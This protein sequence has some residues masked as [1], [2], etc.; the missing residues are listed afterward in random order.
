MRKDDAIRLRHMLDAAHE[1]MGFVQ[2]RTR[3]D[4]NDDR[5]LVL[6][7]VKDI[8]I[9]GEAAH[10]ALHDAGWLRWR[11][12]NR[13]AA[14]MV[15]RIPGGFHSK[16]GDPWHSLN[17]EMEFVHL[18]GWRVAFPSNA[19]DAVGLLRAALRGNDPVIF[20]EHRMLLGRA[21]GEYPGDDFLLPFGQASVALEGEELTV[22][23][24]SEM[25]NRCVAAARELGG[26]VEVVDPRTLVPLDRETV[27]ASV[28]RTGK[29]LVVHEDQLT[30]G[31]GG[32]IAA[33]VADHCFEWL[34]GPVRR[35]A[36][37]FSPVPYN[38]R[39]MNHVIPSVEGIRRAMEELLAY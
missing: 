18:M 19:R 36:P 39:L 31:F 35:L 8:E 5:M 9:I 27:Y 2:G 3:A 25:L 22:V 7:L 13:F 4:L 11:S 14:P 6:S 37:P 24:W 17:T 29:C 30:A 16:T 15:V 1:A 38:E 33:G 26:R 21:V 10:E 28:R 34:D 23:S 20:F 12:A 32:E